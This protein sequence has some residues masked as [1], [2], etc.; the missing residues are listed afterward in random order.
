MTHYQN[1]GSDQG[2]RVNG[3]EESSSPTMEAQRGSWKYIEQIFTRCFSES[4][5]NQGKVTQGKHP[6][7]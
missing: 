6:F 2:S 7:L 3:K 1:L 4:G 5:G